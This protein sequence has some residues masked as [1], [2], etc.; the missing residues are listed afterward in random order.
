[1]NLKKRA[2]ISVTNKSSLKEFR[3]LAQVGWEIVSTGNT[4]KALETLGIDHIPVQDVTH[5]PEMMDGRL[6]TLHPNIFG[7]ILA[8]QDNQKHLAEISEHGIDCFGIVAVN[9]YG[10]KKNPCIEN[11]D[12]G[13]PALLRAAAKNHTS[14]AGICDPDDYGWVIDEILE[15]KGLCLDTL[16]CLAAKTFEATSEYDLMISDWM[17]ERR[18]KGIPLRDPA[19]VS[20]H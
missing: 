8:D 9:L 14:I 2:L 1:M 15:G 19:S 20:A 12:I 18:E 17:R 16:E 5:F 13:G 4:A 6:K 7:G 11:I 3:R 10:F